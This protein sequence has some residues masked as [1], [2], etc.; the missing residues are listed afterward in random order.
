MHKR[1]WLFA[2]AAA[3]LLLVVA[4]ATATTKVASSAHV[5]SATPAAAPFAQSWAHVPR[6]TAA[7]KA[8]NVVVFGMEQD[9]DG[10][11]TAL[12]C[13]NA[14]WAGVTGNVPVTRGAY[15]T[16][17]KLQHV[18]DTVVA[19]KATPTT[20]SYVIR[21]NANW[22]WGGKKVPVTYKDF[23]YTWQ[24]IVDP[25]NDVVGRDG[26]DQITG[27]THKGDK[28]I[29]FKWKKPYA[30]WQDL[31]GSLYPSQALAGMD[32]N[33]IWSNCVCGS[34]GQPVSNG[35]YYVSNYT[36]GQ[37]MTLKANPL[38]W[39]KKQAIKEVDFKLITDTNTEVQAMRG[40]EV[41]AISPTFGVNLA[42]LKGVSGITFNQVPGLYQEHIDIQ[43]GPK[44]QPLLRS[45]WMRKALM[46]GIDRQAIIKTVYGSLAG[47][48]TPLDNILFYSTDAEYKPDFAQWNFNP[49]K[50]LA[51]LK[52]HCQGGP[53]A[54]SQSNTATW[55]CSGY[56]AKFRYTWTASNATRTTQEAI[57][58]QELK[59]IGVDIV[60]SALPANVVFG[61][62]GIP[63][64]NYD[65]ANFAWVTS[66]DPSGFVPT[67]G[68][69][70]ESN[71]LLYCNRAA[72]KLLEA[73]NSELD[74]AKRMK[75]FQAA[76]AL[77]AKDVPTIPLYQRPN[78]L[79]Y[80]SDLLGMK[81]NASLTGFSWN[82]EE[83]HWKS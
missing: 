27:F 72:T 22:Y 7:R 14:F 28:Q 53:A 32:F 10:F 33:K 15:I 18:L 42:Q 39:G 47:N 74:P 56:P 71:Y 26:Y 51:L 55:T 4:S 76:D 20:L 78:P 12:T 1:L 58:K 75:M 3:V 60:D 63:S 25:K 77:M 82:M 45:P 61:P 17:N 23:V 52:Q 64:S 38:W 37:G 11:N 50:A 44:G 29:T 68:C 31:F 36:K 35:P 73:S 9:I 46:M 81:N 67:W 34:D 49:A 21:P 80:K 8:K 24:Q 40:G 16:N 59:S 2:G 65:L 43:F 57:I 79:I 41:D 66:P 13:C 62:T 70:G 30:D 5:S 83:W 54:V 19:G 69:G 48:T 6:T